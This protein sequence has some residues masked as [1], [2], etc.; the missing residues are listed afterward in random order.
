[1][2]LPRPGQELHLDR[3]I[4][5]DK[6]GIEAFIRFLDSAPLHCDFKSLYQGSWNMGASFPPDD[7]ARF[8]PVLA[9]LA[10]IDV[11]LCSKDAEVRQTMSNLVS[12]VRGPDNPNE[13]N[14]KDEYT[15]PIR[16]AMFPELAKAYH[17]GLGSCIMMAR[18]GT[19]LKEIDGLSI[20]TQTHYQ[21]HINWAVQALRRIGRDV[22]AEPPPVTMTFGTIK[23]GQL[24]KF[25]GS[26]I[27]SVYMK[28]DPDIKHANI[29]TDKDSASGGTINKEG[30]IGWERHT[31]SVIPVTG[32]E[33]TPVTQYPVGSKVTYADVRPGQYFKPVADA[34]STVY[35]RLSPEDKLYG[36]SIESDT[37]GKVNIDKAGSRT[38]VSNMSWPVIIVR[39]WDGGTE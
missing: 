3:L 5:T 21:K 12:A 16:S 7:K 4:S 15:T 19:P 17:K 28:L 31:T 22:V 24:F 14:L 30:H 32:W 9:A 33:G 35:R 11:A 18:P 39:D 38:W 25:P 10:A 37:I 36:N 27:G 13:N 2:A 8:A 26:Q 29:R 1:M 34:G 20:I 23:P 6:S